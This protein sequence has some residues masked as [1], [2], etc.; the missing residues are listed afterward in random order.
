MSRRGLRAHHACCEAGAEVG[1]VAP[2][3]HAAFAAGGLDAFASDRR[4]LEQ[5]IACS[6]AKTAASESANRMRSR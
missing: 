6:Q 3:E 5:R 4:E 1:F 2:A